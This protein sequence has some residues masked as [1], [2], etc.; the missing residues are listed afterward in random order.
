[1]AFFTRLIVLLAAVLLNGCEQPDA[2]PLDQQLYVWQRQ[3]T[4][5]HDAALR[6]SLSLIHI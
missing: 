2:L 6:D 5:A 4:P 1:M 3:W